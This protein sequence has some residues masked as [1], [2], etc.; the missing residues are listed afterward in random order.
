MT[1]KQSGSN[2]LGHPVIYTQASLLTSLIGFL[3]LLETS[4]VYSGN[5]FRRL[6]AIFS[7]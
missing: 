3:N 7:N 5:Q 6:A 4:F 2:I 1:K